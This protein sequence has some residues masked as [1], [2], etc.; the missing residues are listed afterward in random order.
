MPAPESKKF[1]P[2]LRLD[3]ALL[4]MALLF[5]AYS[6]H[7]FFAPQRVVTKAAPVRSLASLPVPTAPTER[8]TKVMD[9]GCFVGGSQKIRTEAALLQLSATICSAAPTQGKNETTGES[10]LL[11][12]QGKK[13]VSHY[14][15]LR[16]GANRIWLEGAGIR[17]SV[18]V[19][20]GIRP[21]N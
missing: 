1:V 13:V 4:A 2:S 19:E 10:L 20:H 6:V 15:P 12:R 17:Q 21:A 18:E 7:V 9:L 16:E 14:F 11:F 3:L 8:S 5:A